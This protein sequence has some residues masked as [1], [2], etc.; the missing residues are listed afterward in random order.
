M[1]EQTIISKSSAFVKNSA[2]VKIAV[3][4]FITLLLLIPVSMVKSLIGERGNRQMEVISEISEKW[5]GSQTVAG[6]VLTIPYK[7]YINNEDKAPVTITRYIHF[8]PDI[9]KIKGTMEP[10]IRYRGI[11]EALLYSSDIEIAGEF[12]Y[13]DVERLGISFNDIMWDRAFISMGLTDMG[14]IRS[15]ISGM[16]EESDVILE[17]GIETDDLFKTGVSVTLAL[18]KEFT[19]LPFNFHISINGNGKLFFLPLG[20]ETT[21]ALTSEWSSPSFTGQF[22]P[23]Q[24]TLDSNGFSAGWHILHL[25]RNY[26][27][28]WVGSK[29]DLNSS[30]FGVALHPGTEIYQKTTRTA[31]Y[32]VMFI[33]FTFT[34]FFLSE[35]IN[36][37]RIHPIQY[38]LVGSSVIIFYVLLLALSEH[39]GFNTSFLAS[40]LSVVFLISGYTRSILSKK[41]GRALFGILTILYGYLFITLQLEDY[42]L[43]FGSLGLFT[44]LSAVMYLTRKVD[45]YSLQ[46]VTDQND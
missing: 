9:L 11:Y 25:N 2:S 4:I 39:L 21:V 35:V 14:G 40:A 16:V 3:I 42:A 15:Q 38:L 20:K 17:P 30:A 24:R 43:L 26:P 13:P 27:Q 1:E 45:W 10:Q 22:L 46:T 31:K 29:C 8:L 6:P 36:R 34:A 18:N 7:S 12:P 41:M 19:S 28:S 37:A 32:G 33:L 23:G 5:G 44:T